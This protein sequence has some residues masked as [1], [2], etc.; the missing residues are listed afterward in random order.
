MRPHGLKTRLLLHLYLHLY[1]LRL[2]NKRSDA[3]RPSTVAFTAMWKR[4]KQITVQ[5]SWICDEIIRPDC[6]TRDTMGYLQ[7]RKW[8]AILSVWCIPSNCPTLIPSFK[9]LKSNSSTLILAVFERLPGRHGPC[10]W[11]R[12]RLAQSGWAG[13]CRQREAPWYRR[14]A[15]VCGNLAAGL[16]K[17]EE[18]GE[19]GETGRMATQGRGCSSRRPQSPCWAWS[20]CSKSPLRRRYSPSHSYAYEQRDRRRPFPWILSILYVWR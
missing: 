20:L 10:G 3:L 1:L 6:Y 9:K 18:K 8:F 19:V 13:C 17:G 16:E 4:G 14:T 11:G 15:E 12:V 2:A 5:V 7:W